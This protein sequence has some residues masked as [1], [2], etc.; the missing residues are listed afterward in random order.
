MEQS[1]KRL[2]LDYSL[3]VND[4]SLDPSIASPLP[5]G[6]G[7]LDLS[8]AS[9]SQDLIVRQ[10]EQ[11]DVRSQTRLGFD[12]ISNQG[13]TQNNWTSSQPL[14]G[15]S[16]SQIL[17]STPLALTSR[18]SIEL[19]TLD[20]D[21][22][23]SKNSQNFEEPLSIEQLA[24]I[25]AHEQGNSSHQE[26]LYLEECEDPEKHKHSLEV[27]SQLSQEGLL[28]NS[29]LRSRTCHYSDCGKEFSKSNHL[30]NHRITFH[31][32]TGTLFFCSHCD[33]HFRTR[34]SFNSHQRNV[35]SG[36]IY[37]KYCDSLFLEVNKKQ[38]FRGPRHL[39]MFMNQM[40]EPTGV[41]RKG[42]AKGD[43]NIVLTLPF[44]I[45]LALIILQA[46]KQEIKSD[47]IVADVTGSSETFL[48]YKLQKL[49][50]VLITND[51]FKKANYHYDI[52]DDHERASLLAVLKSCGCQMWIGSVPYA[53]TVYRILN[54]FIRTIPVLLIKLPLD[55]VSKNKGTKVMKKAKTFSIPSSTYPP[56]KSPLRERE[57]WCLWI[58]GKKNRNKDYY[59]KYLELLETSSDYIEKLQKWDKVAVETFR[60]FF[61]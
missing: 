59:K 51:I 14:S 12:Y 31:G 21:G 5:C 6:S 27:L 18:P 15:D 25:S 2:R 26:E 23:G 19:G 9:Q 13:I 47:Y 55:F 22:F 56:H 58:K 60:I 37:C 43:K 46:Y 45:V 24:F 33:H 11:S 35:S 61:F 48:S 7:L 8:L 1:G 40:P 20:Q 3:L 32:E 49:C 29:S 4:D 57:V 17:P 10:L 36:K 44:Q 39:K 16:F 42:S 30:L 53:M 52:R 34:E 50:K 28:T 38:H 54:D 41:G